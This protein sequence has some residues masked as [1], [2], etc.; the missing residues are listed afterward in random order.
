[1]KTVLKVLAV[2]FVGLPLWFLAWREYDEWRLESAWMEHRECMR[3]LWKFSKGE[4]PPE[5]KQVVERTKH[6]SDTFGD[7]WNV[8]GFPV[9]TA[10]GVKDEAGK[11]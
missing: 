8:R 5:Y 7:A 10:M 11:R 9:T 2:L 4:P 3:S 1:M 6:L